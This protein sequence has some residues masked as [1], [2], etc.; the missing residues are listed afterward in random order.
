MEM[1]GKRFDLVF[2]QVDWTELSLSKES[3]WTGDGDL[4]LSKESD[5]TG[6]GDRAL[7]LI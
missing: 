7:S 3:D 5:W 2:H 4:S 1:Y 6:D